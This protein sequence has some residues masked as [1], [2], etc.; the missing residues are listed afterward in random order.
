MHYAVLCSPDSWYLK[1]LRRAGAGRCEITAVNF[2][3]LVAQLVAPAPRFLAGP[4][5]LADCDAVLVRTMPPGTLEQVVFRMD[6]LARLEAAGKLVVNPPK[7]IEMAVDKYLASARL[8]AAGLT[9]PRTMVCQT[10]EAALAAF[11]ALGGDVVLKPL[12]GAEGRGIARLNDPALAERAFRMLAQ[13]GAVLYLQEFIPHDGCD[14]RVLVVG[15]RMWA[16]RRANPL[17]WRTNVSRGAI[18]EPWELT[19][20]LAALSRRAT[21]A[22]GAL[23]AGVDLLP[24]RDGKLY[25]LEVNAVP[26]WQALSRTLQV[27]IAREV[28]DF[29]EQRAKGESRQRLTT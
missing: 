14:L 8:A 1:D 13:M 9:T 11:E 19:A 23:V 26:G 27:D 3:D 15:E 7:S 25:V 21:D 6:L 4:L 2:R 29:V 10:H 5:D 12:F 22:V 17:D 20:E 18:A 16:M 28:L 24:G